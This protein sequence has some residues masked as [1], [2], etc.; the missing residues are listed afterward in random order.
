MPALDDRGADE[1]V[2]LAL[3]EG[4]DDLL[5][6][7]LVHLPVGDGDARLGHEVAHVLGGS[8]DVEHAVVDVEHLAFTE[9]LASDGLGHGAVVVLADV[10]EDRHAV[11]RRRVEQREVADAGEAHLQGARYRRGREREHVDAGLQR[12]DLLLVGH[13]EALLLVDHQ[14]PEILEAD[15]FAQQPV[16]ADHHV[17]R[18]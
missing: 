5:E 14:Q 9:Q 11:G 10:G 3:P 13:A 1:H 8:L 16:G 15:V 18:A 7:A 12:L 4:D 17:D 6:G 2:V